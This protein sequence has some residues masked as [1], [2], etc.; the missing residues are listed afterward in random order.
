M[1]RLERVFRVETY[2]VIKFHCSDALVDARDDLL[3]N[4]GGVDMLG[5]EAITETRNTSGDLVELDALFA[6]I[7]HCD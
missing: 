2:E 4:C 1:T 7:C 6:S 5:V 3:R